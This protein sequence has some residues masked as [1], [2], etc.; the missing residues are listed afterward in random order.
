VIAGPADD[1]EAAAP[2]SRITYVT[3]ADAAFFVGAV[4]MLNSL[5]LTGNHE[6][7]VVIDVGLTSEQRAILG[8]HCELREPPS[9]KEGPL[10]VLLKS[11]MHLLGVTGI[12]VLLDTDVVLTRRLTPIL[13]DAAA[14]N[15][16]V[17]AD[18]LPE[19][20]FE[21]WSTVLGLAQPPRS[22][23]HVGAGFIALD[24]DQ[25]PDFMPRWHELC[26]RV[27]ASRAELPFD[28]PHEEFLAHPFALPEQDVLNAYLSTEVP[29]E[30]LS[31]YELDVFPGPP[32]NDTL[33]IVDR[34]TLRCDN[35]GHEPFQLHYWNHP[36]PW[37]AD[38]RPHLAMDAYVELLARLLCADDVPIRLDPQTLPVWLRDDLRG[39]LV[40][41]TPR[42][43]R[44]GLRAALGLLPPGL[45]RRARD[46]G[47]AVAERLRLG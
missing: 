22:Q 30:R 33:R 31:I 25:W 42:H 17:V 44:R 7:V 27:P 8:P 5:R 36:K 26:E 4:G 24:L 12:V 11:S 38:A 1:R 6:P 10:V 23:R 18:Q 16:V 14:G 45:E 2:A 35:A 39:R 34:R 21:E 37:R 20:R 15:V 43:L 32:H 46:V 40:R 47:G 13:D 3:I 41:R 19:R 29:A 9:T 28:L